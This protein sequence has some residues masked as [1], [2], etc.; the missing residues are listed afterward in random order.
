M[1][2]FYLAGKPKSNSEASLYVGFKRN[3]D[4]ITD[5]GH[6]DFNKE[7][8]SK[9]DYINA[10]LYVTLSQ[11]DM[12]TGALSEVKR[13]FHEADFSRI[14][15]SMNTFLNRDNYLGLIHSEPDPQSFFNI[16][17]NEDFDFDLIPL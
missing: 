15:L 1:R 14:E 2:S 6:P 10:V 7:L 5:R 13:D 3:P 12:K 4:M 17:E 8:L 16:E 11:V 9:V